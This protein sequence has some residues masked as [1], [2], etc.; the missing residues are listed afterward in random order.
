MSKKLITD[1][2]TPCAEAWDADRIALVERVESELD[3]RICGAVGMDGSP[4]PRKSDHPTGRCTHH[5]GNHLVGGQPG[6][7]NARVHGLYARRLM[8][9]DN[10][11]A[12]WKE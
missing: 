2:G 6:N 11:C 10:R 3:R 5:G 9:C 1:R 7:E 8:T 12:M 4:C